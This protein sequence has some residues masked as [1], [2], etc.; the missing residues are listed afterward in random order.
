MEGVICVG[1]RVDREL[2][3][4][5]EG[6]G[7]VRAD[8]RR[9]PHQIRQALTMTAERQSRPGRVSTVIRIVTTAVLLIKPLSEFTVLAAD[10]YAPYMFLQIDG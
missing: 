2:V 10:D 3:V 1:G 6:G 5:A 8:P 4:K 7:C 9:Q